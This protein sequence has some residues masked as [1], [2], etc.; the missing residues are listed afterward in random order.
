[1]WRIG[2]FSLAVKRGLAIASQSGKR[3]NFGNTF[4]PR[5]ERHQHMYFHQHHQPYPTGVGG[6]NSNH[7][8]K[9]NINS[10]C[11]TWICTGDNDKTRHR[12]QP[13]S[14]DDLQPH[15]D[16]HCGRPL[17]LSPSSSPN[18]LQFNTL[19]SP[20]QLPNTSIAYK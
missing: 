1:M 13:K 18:G 2:R 15:P 8:A 3:Q 10:S 16:C 5:L 7:Y 6:Y 4:Q 20:A 17:N 14:C 12:F 9:L 19:F 11:F